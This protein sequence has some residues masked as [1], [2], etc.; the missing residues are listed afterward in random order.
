MGAHVVCTFISH[1]TSQTTRPY[2]ALPAHTCWYAGCGWMSIQHACVLPSSLRLCEAQIIVEIIHPISIE[3][4]LAQAVV[5]WLGTK[6][7]YRFIPA[8]TG[9]PCEAVVSGRTCA[10]C[11]YRTPNLSHRML[12]TKRL[13][14]CLAVASTCLNFDTAAAGT[15]C[16]HRHTH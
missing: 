15:L 10:R 13:A 16:D 4:T 6:F 2:P 14:A 7:I 3:H 12:P 11:P 5:P 9:R 8:S 1:R